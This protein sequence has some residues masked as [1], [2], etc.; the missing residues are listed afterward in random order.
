[1]KRILVLLGREIIKNFKILFRNWTT[2]SL[3][4]IAPLLLILLVGYAFSGENLHDITIGIIS[5]NG[6]DITEFRQNTSDYAQI[7]EYKNLS[8]CLG[9]MIV[10]KSHLCIM[11]EGSIA[12]DENAPPAH[13]TFFYD[14]TKTKTNAI[15]ISQVKEFFGL[16]AQKISLIA[17]R[18]MFDNIQELVVF[19][20]E[21]GYEIEQLK[22]N[23][24]EIRAQLQERKEKL[25][26]LRNQFQPSYQRLKGL[27]QNLNENIERMLVAQE[28]SQD[29]LHSLANN[30]ANISEELSALKS[31][32]NSS[33][34]SNTTREIPLDEL[35]NKSIELANSTQE[36]E[37]ELSELRYSLITLEQQINTTV[38][39]IDEF[40]VL[41]DKEIEL[42]SY[43]ITVIDKSTVRI[44]ELAQNLNEKMKEFR[45]I[46]PKAA[47]RLV[48]PIAQSVQ[49]LLQNA[50]NIGLSFPLLVAMITIFISLLFA[51][52]VTLAEINDRSYTRKLLAPVD[53]L[54]YTIGLI[55]TNSLVILLQVSVLFLI[56]YVQFDLPILTF[57]GELFIVIGILIL[58][59]TFM[60]MTIAYLSRNTQASILLATF[61]ALAFFLLSDAVVGLE[62]MP[63]Y[64]TA[65]AAYN[66]LM[67]S[68]SMIKVLLL[69]HQSIAVAS[70]QLLIMIVY[71]CAMFGAALV[72]SKR[73]NR[74]RL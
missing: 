6:I 17:A 25:E 37:K 47:E 11:M 66:P 67:L 73:F 69:Y 60:G 29:S 23:T 41:L 50:T 26:N 38:G 10:E 51:N 22:N 12:S 30:L 21:R 2:L 57:L 49:P 54:L 56:A 31:M 35:R 28:R 74:K 20:E 7:Q 62:A 39:Y 55:I 36:N 64:A 15:L 3:L 44:A 1:M 48:T 19:L 53:D 18:T 34:I 24:A 27:Q 70:H 13:I 58:L 68:S 33:G 59:F 45:G 16:S 61:I 5:E 32:R 9:E 71:A 43:Y 42:T 65:V 8:A 4:I 63:P 72:A 40:G 52:I 46:G 14:N